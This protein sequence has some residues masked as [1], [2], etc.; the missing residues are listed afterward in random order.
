[1]VNETEKANVNE[2]TEELRKKFF[3]DAGIYEE[4]LLEGHI[5]KT[6]EHAQLTSDGRIVFNNELLTDRQKVGI[7]ILCRCLGSK[8]DDKIEESVTNKEISEL[9]GIEPKSARARLSNLIDENVI[10]RVSRGVHR[11]NYNK[12]DDFIDS[13]TE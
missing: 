6:M 5:D 1:M 10:I 8:L 7:V 11:I 13:I 12:I 2:K 3:I 9:T 4:Q